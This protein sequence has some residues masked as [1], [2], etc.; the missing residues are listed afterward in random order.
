M[1]RTPSSR[2]ASFLRSAGVGIVASLADLLVLVLLVE[3]LHRSPVV[4]NVPALL[5]G[6]SIQFW[7]NKLFAFRDRSRDLA[8]QGGQFAAVELGAFGLNGLG[9][10]LAVGM[11]RLPY[12]LARVLCSALVYMAYSFPLWR[13]IFRPGR[14][15]R[16]PGHEEGRAC[17]SS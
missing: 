12:A 1:S 10:Q 2:V 14:R 6:L 9:F 13:F 11:L 15:V 8:R 3:G 4:A 16:R 17:S 7:G 5:V